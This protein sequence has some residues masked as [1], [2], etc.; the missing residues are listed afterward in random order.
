LLC[1]EARSA[2]TIGRVTSHQ[3]FEWRP[4]DRGQVR[5]WAELVAAT[6]AVDHQDEHFGEDDLI[7]EFDDPDCDFPDGSI[8][9]YDGAVMVG[10]GVLGMRSAAEP[11]HD[12]G[13]MGAVHPAYRG[14]GIGSAILDWSEHASAILHERRF[15]GRPLSLDGRCQA[16]NEGAVALFE[17]HGYKP[18]RWF[19]RM[20]C[21]LTSE[22]PAMQVPAGVEI[23]G[24]T[25]KRS[26]DARLVR[27]EAFRDHWRSTENTDESW[28]HFIGFQAF[29]P[30]YSFVAYDADSG[31]PLGVVLAHEYDSYTRATGRLELYIPTVATRRIG[32]K[33]GIASA[34][35]MQT[36]HAA[37]AAGFVSVTLDVDS[38]SQTGAVGLYERAGFTVQDIWVTQTK[39]LIA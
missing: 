31:Q 37:K 35:L 6:E 28:A 24:Y 20:S 19:L 17:D 5:A 23:I 15:P 16:R 7:E 36:M 22:L 13:A 39:Q 12:M 32:R 26:Q 27:D 2:F 10:W 25:P 33:R 8:A 3:K 18:S 38:D 30:A 4:I 11:V 1:R 9:A 14:R 29:R 34:L 21:P